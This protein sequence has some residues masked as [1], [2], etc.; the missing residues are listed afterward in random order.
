[1][2]RKECLD[3][4]AKAVLTDRSQQYGEPEDSFAAIAGMWS[5][6]LGHPVSS[7]DVALMLALLKIVR[8]KSNPR[9]DDS[10]V[11]IAGYAVCGAECADQMCGCEKIEGLEA[12]MVGTPALTRD[13]IPSTGN[14]HGGMMMD[15]RH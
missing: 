12:A 10:W 14:N 6:Y 15:L 11:D 13:E 4:A 7:C 8:A 9:H 3:A 5:V 1:M 2:T